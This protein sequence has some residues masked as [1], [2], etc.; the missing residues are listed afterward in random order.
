MDTAASQ[1]SQS[2]Q[3]DFINVYE[4]SD[5]LDLNPPHQL[6]AEAGYII[7][8]KGPVSTTAL[9]DPSLS[10]NLI[11]QSCATRL[12]LEIED[13]GT[14]EE[15]IVGPWVNFRDGQRQ[16]PV[17][18]LKLEWNDGLSASNVSFSVRCWVFEHSLRN[19]VLGK[20]F[21]KKRNHYRNR[22]RD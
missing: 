7:T 5:F 12:G 4:N 21:I 9:I 6:I 14:E 2:S 19:V 22:G 8:P 20:P 3:G 11:S 15:E 16:R 17:G 10:E 1:H 18:K 13:L